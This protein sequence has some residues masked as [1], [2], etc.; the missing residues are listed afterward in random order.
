MY[1]PQV[2]GAST[3]LPNTGSSNVAFIT[4]AIMLVIGVAIVTTTILRIVLK[5][6]AAK[7]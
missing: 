3:S 2:L 1:Q 7:A 4:G 6:K 5:K